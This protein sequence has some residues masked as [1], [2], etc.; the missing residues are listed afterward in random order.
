MSMDRGAFSGGSPGATRPRRTPAAMQE[1]PGIRFRRDAR[2]AF[3]G[4]EASVRADASAPL[5]MLSA[6]FEVSWFRPLGPRLW[7]AVLKPSEA[8]GEDFGLR[9]E[10]YVVGH[11]LPRDFNEKTLLQ[12]PPPDAGFHV[13]PKVRFVVSGTPLAAAAC[14][15]WSARSRTSV[16]VVSPNA[17]HRAVSAEDHLYKLLGSSNRRRD[18]FA[19]PGP[20]R[21]PS[22]F[23]GRESVVH[24]VLT[25]ILA[26]SPVGVFGL[27]RI[28]KSSLL[29]HVEGLLE[30]DDTSV[31]ATSF[32]LGNTARLGAGRWWLAA[33]DMLAAWQQKL[34]RFALKSDSKIRPKAEAFSAAI[35]GNVTDARKLAAAFEKD[36]RGLLKAAE[37]LARES[38]RPSFRLVCFL[39]EFDHLYPAGAHCGYW[40][41]DFFTLWNTIHSVRCSLD[42]PDR[43]TFVVGGVNPAGVEH[44]TWLHQPNPLFET[45]AVFLGPMPPD[46][47][48][49]LLTDIGRRMGLAFTRE[50][51]D[52]AY[53][54]VGG[55]PHL[56]RKLG[57]QL[58]KENLG[59]GSSVDVTPHR[60][61]GAFKKSKRSFL[62]QIEWTLGHLTSVAP[63]EVKLLRDLATGGPQA[64]VDL[65]G[66]VE[67]R[68]TFAHHL[69]RYGL[70][71]FDDD[72]PAVATPVIL[73]AIRRP[74]PSEFEEQFRLL[75]ELVDSVEDALRRRLS[76]DLSVTAPEAERGGAGAGHSAEEALHALINAIPSDAKNRAL[77]R[78]QLLDIGA[79][80]GIGA[81]LESL[82]W[83]DY[84]ILLAKFFDAIAWFGPAMERAE[85]LRFIRDRANECH[86]VRHN[87]R[88][89][90]K[91]LIARD[92]FAEVF[93]RI[94]DVRE[95]CSR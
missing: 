52:A 92:G 35:K 10:C 34:I 86:L 12:A 77:T 89:E 68:E 21:C 38:E 30:S 25:H 5:E 93:R 69:E 55:Y 24:E 63:E 85:R 62:S 17:R 79:S 45:H 84:E 76:A 1:A 80:S 27:R 42:H 72:R 41:E 39:D 6:G 9:Q 95:M 7:A 75:K 87:N 73:E 65:W 23:F 29:S 81:V 94:A 43:L 44:G 67:N 46:E 31:T 64:Y 36:V 40:R 8:L 71:E 49:G 47:A 56:L 90:L 91:A 14:A 3:E 18:L 61:V 33:S 2:E 60:V 19:E 57:T 53:S 59:R 37:A 66:G 82:G 32:L 28:G 78:Q 15:A 54:L 22:E 13:D 50:A 48:A 16:V 11:G 58:H 4:A 88:I 83:N 51:T 74:L 26:G 20:V 70:I